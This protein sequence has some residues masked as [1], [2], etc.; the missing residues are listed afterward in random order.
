MKR[1]YVNSVCWIRTQSCHYKV[2]G[3]VSHFN[4]FV[5]LI[6]FSDQLKASGSLM[7]F[8][9]PTKWSEEPQPGHKMS[10][11]SSGVKLG[12]HASSSLDMLQAERVTVIFSFIFLKNCLLSPILV[13]ELFVCGVESGRGAQVTG[14]TLRSPFGLLAWQVFKCTMRDKCFCP[15]KYPCPC[16]ADQLLPFLQQRSMNFH[17]RWFF[18]RPWKFSHTFSFSA[19][20]VFFPHGRSISA[21]K[22]TCIILSFKPDET[23]AFTLPLHEL[24]YK[25]VPLHSRILP[26]T[27]LG[28]GYGT[29]MLH[30]DFISDVGMARKL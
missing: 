6:F 17:S 25:T 29:G 23:S 21:L 2:T 12:W 5:G 19:L 28:L 7:S 20:W 18:L 1:S 30:S 9:V 14:L 3:L 27:S 8:L 4:S 15:W 13:P 26:W 16:G 10:G 11:T 24:S 22:D